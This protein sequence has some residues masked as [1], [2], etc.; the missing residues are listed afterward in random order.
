[1]R[2]PMKFGNLIA[3]KSTGKIILITGITLAISLLL[4]SPNILQVSASLVAGGTTDAGYQVFSSSPGPLIELWSFWTVP[5]VQC[6][7][8]GFVN[9]YIVVGHI[10]VDDIGSRL[11]VT[12]TGTT[13]T[14]SINYIA[15]AGGFTLPAQDTV[16][17]GDKIQTIADEAVN[18]GQTFVSI[19]DMTKAWSFS[20]NDKELVNTHAVGLAWWFLTAS[21]PLANFSPIKTTKDNVTLNNHFGSIGAYIPLTGFTVFKDVLKNSANNHVLAKPTSITKASLGFSLKW[22]QGS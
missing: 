21:T 20:T 18:G 1:M 11:V 12:C 16:S 14:Y 19:K 13:A 4:I 7:S 6:T 17:P 8:S 3:C 2:F 15:T 9:F 5:T 10:S 22:V